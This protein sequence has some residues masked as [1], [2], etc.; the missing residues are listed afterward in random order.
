MTLSRQHLPAIFAIAVPMVLSNITV[1]LLGLV[2]TAVVGHLSDSLYL[3]GVALGSSVITFL[4]WIVGFLR[5]STTGSVAQ[6]MGRKNYR[7]AVMVWR[8][9]VLLGLLI[10]AFLIILQR[11]LWDFA[12]LLAAPDPAVAAEAYS[13]FQIRIWGA[14]AALTNLSTLGCLLGMR[15]ARAPMWLLIFANLINI[16]GDL[17]FVVGMGWDVSGVAAAS[18]LADLFGAVAG[19]W[20]LNRLW[21][22]HDISLF[23]RNGSATGLELS[24]LGRLLSLNRDIFLRTLALQLCFT[25]MTFQGT[26]LGQDILAA[27]MVLLNFLLLVS[28]ALDGF[29]YAVEALA[30]EALGAGDRK[31]FEQLISTTLTLSFAV[32][33]LFCSG[34]A[35]FGNSIVNL[36]TDIDSVRETAA[37]YIGWLIGLPAIAVWSYLF[38]GIYIGATQAR[39]MRNAMMICSFLVFFP[40]WWLFRDWGNHALWLAM[41]VF[42]LARGMSLGWHYRRHHHAWFSSS[43]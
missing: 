35:L 41:T 13:Y 6:A 12:V 8:H 37:D 15:Q 19:I 36:L 22:Q 2:D 3:A 9:S 25:F 28:F 11:P 40:T 5:M 24:G 4:F 10:S 39:V 33:L 1:P 14:P 17:G 32:S 29:A 30:G 16:C 31:L 34:F 42:M 26:R 21:Q 27:N 23:R 43:R 7:Q 38:D 20:T 18:L